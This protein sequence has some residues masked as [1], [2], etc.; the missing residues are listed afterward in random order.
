MVLVLNE[1]KHFIRS[2]DLYV[3]TV[4]FINKWNLSL[5]GSPMSRIRG[6]KASPV[7]REIK[8]D[9]QKEVYIFFW[10]YKTIIIKREVIRKNE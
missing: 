4:N 2:Q 3:Y 10:G 9:P 1:A 7:K 5:L 6:L 8:E